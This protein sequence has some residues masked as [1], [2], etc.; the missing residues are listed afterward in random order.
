MSKLRY[1][2]PMGLYVAGYNCVVGRFMCRIMN[3]SKLV[4]MKTTYD[5][6]YTRFKEQKHLIDQLLAERKWQDIA[7]APKD[8]TDIIVF[9]VLSGRGGV[10]FFGWDGDAYDDPVPPFQVFISFNESCETPTHWMPLPQPP[11]EETSA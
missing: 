6:R 8:G 11:N 9:D 4:A 7:S 1:R 2:Q 5:P 10:G 3:G